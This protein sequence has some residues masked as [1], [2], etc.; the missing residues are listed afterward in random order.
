MSQSRIIQPT[1]VHFKTLSPFQ[2]VSMFQAY[3]GVSEYSKNKWPV[4]GCLFLFTSHDVDAE[5]VCDFESVFLFIGILA[6]P[7]AVEEVID[8]IT[9]VG[10][11]QSW[12]FAS[13]SSALESDRDLT[14]KIVCLQ[15][16]YT[17]LDVT[18]VV[19]DLYQIN[20]CSRQ[21]IA[22]LSVWERAE[23]NFQCTWCCDIVKFLIQNWW[24]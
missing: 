7:P 20:L 19:L 12:K 18:H 15:S 8:V 13:G 23:K 2:T 24:W 3:L 6:F 21:D 4:T 16:F 14:I 5:F 1:R 10:Y 22:V 17:N 11:S 9:R